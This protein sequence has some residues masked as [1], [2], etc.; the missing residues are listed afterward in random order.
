[1]SGD[2]KIGIV[3]GVG[4]I[5][6]V[7]KLA[8]SLASAAASGAAAPRAAPSGAMP[9]AGLI[10]LAGELAAQPAPVDTAR[11]AALRGAIAEGLYV[12]DP[13]KIAGAMTDRLGGSA[14]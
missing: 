13:A 12:A 10:R 4:R 6:P 14:D 3:G 5:V 1:M 9:A 2:S 7:R 11:V 8:A